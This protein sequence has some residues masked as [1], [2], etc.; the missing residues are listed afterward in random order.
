MV[1]M[2]A[3]NVEFFIANR[4]PTRVDTKVPSSWNKG[5]ILNLFFGVMLP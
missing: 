1:A 5:N 2:K 3:L 4:P